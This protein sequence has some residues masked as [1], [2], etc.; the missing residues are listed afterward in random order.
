M[1][2]KQI[3]FLNILEIIFIGNPK[4][5]KETEINHKVKKTMKE[6]YEKTFE[7]FK[8]LEQNGYSVIY[9]WETDWKSLNKQDKLQ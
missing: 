5:Y 2:Q 9:I 8:L 1:F 6:L 4:E 3:L 7:R